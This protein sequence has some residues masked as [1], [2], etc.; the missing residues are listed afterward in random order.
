MQCSVTGRA[1]D[2]EV[3]S[4]VPPEGPPPCHSMDKA[5]I[6][7]LWEEFLQFCRVSRQ[8]RSIL[9]M[10]PCTMALI[11]SPVPRRNAH[12]RDTFIDSDGWKI[13]GGRSGVVGS[14]Q[15]VVFRT[16]TM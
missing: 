11:V 2:G 6:Q 16:Q 7:I 13:C 8:K 10:I 14:V 4:V 1:V 5:P 12:V 3:T 15:W 9:L